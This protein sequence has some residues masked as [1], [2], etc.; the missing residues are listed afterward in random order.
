[1]HRLNAEIRTAGLSVFQVLT[2]VPR[3][4][5]EQWAGIGPIVRWLVISRASVLVMTLIAVML[6]GL[7]ALSSGVF[8]L[9]VWLLCVMGSLLA[10]ATN[11]QLNDFTDSVRGI[12][13]DNY[14]RRQYGTHALE[15]GLINR[16]GLLRCIIATG[17][18]ALFVGL[19]IVWLA[20]IA[21]LIPL[22]IGSFFLVFYTYPLKQYG[23]GEIAV[24]FVWGPLLT[25]GTFLAVAGLWDWGVALAGTVNGLGPTAVVFGK[26]IDKIEF[27]RMKGVRTMPVRL[28]PRL[29]RNLVV[30][31]VAMQY[32][33]VVGLAWNGQ[34]RWTALSAL[35][36]I[37]AA[38][39]MVGT[40]RREA[41]DIRPENYPESVWPLWFSAAAFIHT[42]IF[43]LLFLSG[44]FIGEF[45]DLL[46]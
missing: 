19:V 33:G 35:A 25:G 7:F 1:M 36:A 38:L 12:D 18:A 2:G 39:R 30:V 42:R 27:D 37:P 15:E 34:L 31:M 43:G 40:F 5:A 9:Q 44:V 14:F 45:A 10:H 17:S 46:R 23:L 28:G 22:A 21:I 6:G 16:Q 32:I 4:S 11:N 24:L 29:S 3:L 8:D 41:P 13:S 20:G 26:H